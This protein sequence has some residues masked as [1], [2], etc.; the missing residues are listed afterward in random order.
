LLPEGLQ[1]FLS[2]TPPSDEDLRTGAAR[3]LQKSPAGR[4]LV[5]IPTY[6]EA[7]GIGNVLDKTLTAEPSLEI[8]VVDDNSPDQ[9]A[10][11]VQSHPAFHRR[12]HLVKREGK[13]GLGS[14]Y[15]EGFRWATARG[16]DTCIQ[17][18][19]DLSHDPADVPRLI[20][21]LENGADAAIG[22]RYSGGVR[23]MNWP[24]DRLFLSLG[25]SRLVRAL[26]GLPLT[27]VTSG[28]KA[29]RCSALQRLEWD[30]FTTEG[31]GFQVEL[32]FFLW[33]SGARLVEVPIVFTERRSGETKMTVGIAAEA[34]WRV[35]TLA[36]FKR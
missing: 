29:I 35:V 31:Y 18:D 21:A 10:K 6:N 22:S 36:I 30:R 20:E 27:D 1:R 16:F 26:T 13:L 4:I 14:A 24:Q 12:V 11:M 8:L 15:K 23:V 25:A 3:V 2:Q 9:T 32:H 5:I 19:A 28:F 17:I 33:K 7:P 34:A